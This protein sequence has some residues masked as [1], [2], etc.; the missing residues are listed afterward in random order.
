MAT[1]R[2]GKLPGISLRLQLHLLI[3]LVALLT[4]ASSL[5][6]SVQSTQDY[7]NSQMKSHA[8]DTATSLGLSISSYMDDP[9][10]V[11]A[12]TMVSAIFD[13]GFYEELKFT[14][15]AGEVK[16]H[17]QNP[18]E[19]D[20][21]PNWFIQMFPLSPPTMSS[22][23]NNGWVKAGVLSVKS[24]AGVGYKT[25]WQ[26]AKQSAY[27][28]AA[29]TIFSIVFIHLIAYA[30]LRPLHQIERQAQEV[31][32]K[33][34]TQL[35]KL[36]FTTDL[37]S[38]VKAMNSMV[39]NIQSSFAALSKQADELKI[40]VFIDHLTGL[41]NRRLL[42]QRFAAEQQTMANHMTQ[43]H[44]GMFSLH[45]LAEVD[46]VHGYE[47]A[48]QYILRAISEF[49]ELLG[50]GIDCEMFRI[51]GSDLVFLSHEHST[52]LERLLNNLTGRLQTMDSHF[53]CRRL[54]SMPWPN[55]KAWPC[56]STNKW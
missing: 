52:V 39:K 45:S 31:S 54:K 22:E 12:E 24:T 1:I 33:N 34:F 26:Q 2:K 23:V 47:A 28:I 53:N 15:A 38:V 6:L 48:D 27:S 3:V 4:F 46:Q 49:K 40:K 7:L 44:L 30:V 8:Q 14:N 35:D 32:K 10:L 50:K 13:S 5:Y 20:E 21:V 11:I 29:I 41:G 16:I 17:R 56:N 42:E 36:P 55:N 43:L 18:V 9:E 19:F 37:R 51:S 25:L